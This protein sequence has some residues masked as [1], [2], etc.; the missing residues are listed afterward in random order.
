MGESSMSTKSDYIA[1]L[2]Q[3]GLVIYVDEVKFDASKYAFVMYAQSTDSKFGKDQAQLVLSDG[4]VKTVDT[5]DSYTDLVG[6]IV[7]Y[8]ADSNNE[9]VLR[10]A[11]N[12]ATNGTL[13]TQDN[14]A[15]NFGKDGPVTG[16]NAGFEMTNTN[17]KIGSDNV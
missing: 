17:A 14:T 12:Q 5:D 9:Y 8:R 7:Y 2:D 6:K 16:G 3:N 15:V 13:K 4:T 11:A 10:E 1:Y